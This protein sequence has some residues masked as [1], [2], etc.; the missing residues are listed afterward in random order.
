MQ[1][2]PQQGEYCACWGVW[3]VSAQGDRGENDTL[4]NGTEETRETE[5]T[6]RAP[7]PALQVLTQM[8][9]QGCL[10]TPSMHTGDLPSLGCIAG[11]EADRCGF[12]FLLRPWGSC[13]TFL[14]LNS[15]L[16]K[17]R[18]SHTAWGAGLLWGLVK[19]IHV[20]IEQK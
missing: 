4:G 18:S 6:L 16:C 7:G 14:S 9:S 15:L 20:C 2:C 11:Y 1:P 5:L 10:P 13:L 17:I 12:E 8:T 3:V 19:W